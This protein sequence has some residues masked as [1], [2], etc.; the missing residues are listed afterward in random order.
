MIFWTICPKVYRGDKMQYKEMYY[1]M[2]RAS[3]E[4]INILI[5]GQRACEELYMSS[6]DFSLVLLPPDH[7]EQDDGSKTPP[8]L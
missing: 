6:P 5:E 1:R 3:E 2:L 8:P 4:A 7:G